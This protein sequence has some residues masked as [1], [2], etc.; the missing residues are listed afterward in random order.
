MTPNKALKTTRQEQ[1]HP[2][3]YQKIRALYSQDN[4]K[5]F[6]FFYLLLHEWHRNE[7]FPKYILVTDKVTFTKSGVNSFH[8]NQF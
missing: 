4:L 3:H 5:R 1:L 2:C 7:N 8:N 6:E